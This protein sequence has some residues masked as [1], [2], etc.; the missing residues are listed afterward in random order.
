MFKRK[1]HCRVCGQI[2]CSKCT[3]LSD[4][5]ILRDIF[6]NKRFVKTKMRM[7]QPCNEN[8]LDS[9]SSDD[10]LNGGTPIYENNDTESSDKNQQCT[11]YHTSSTPRFEGA[12]AVGSNIKGITSSMPESSQDIRSV[13]CHNANRSS[14]IYH[15][16]QLHEQEDRGNTYESFDKTIDYYKTQKH[17]LDSERNEKVISKTHLANPKLCNEEN[18]IREVST[19]TGYGDF[20][21][22]R[23]RARSQHTHKRKRRNTFSSI[24]GSYNSAPKTINMGQRKK[25]FTARSIRLISTTFVNKTEAPHG[26]V[27]TTNI[28]NLNTASI[29]HAQA[30][31]QQALEKKG[32]AGKLEK[33]VSALMP[34]LLQCI[35]HINLDL[36]VPGGSDFRKIV[37]LKR[38]QGGLPCH[39]TYVD[40]IVFSQSVPLKSMPQI[41]VDPTILL[42]H[43][44]F[45]H[46]RPHVSRIIEVS[47]QEKQR[48]NTLIQRVLQLRPSVVLTTG[49]ASQSVLNKLAKN[50][51]TVLINVK[52]S[53]IERVSRYTGAPITSYESLSHTTQ[54]GYF[55]KFEVKTFRY[56]SDITKYIFLSGIPKGIGCTIVL[57]GADKKSLTSIKYVVKIMVYVMFNLKLE[58][59]LLR[60]EYTKVPEISPLM[61]EIDTIKQKNK[62]A[63][64][65]NLTID[66]PPL[67]EIDN[68]ALNVFNPTF[69]EGKLLSTSPFVN[70]GLPF[71]LQT[72]RKS[73][74]LLVAVGQIKK[75]EIV[76]HKLINKTGLSIENIPGGKDTVNHISELL[77]EYNLKKLY[78]VWSTKAKQWK[79]AFLRNPTMFTPE[80]HLQIVLL[81]SSICTQT[82]VPCHGPELVTFTFYN[83]HADMPLGHFIER[84]CLDANVGCNENCG[85]T[86]KNHTRSY[87]HG[88]GV[89]NITIKNHPCCFSG[90]SDSIFVWSTCKRCSIST[91]ILP[92]S[93]DTWKY[94][95]G[96]YFELSFW[97]S[98]LSF[99]DNICPHNLY[100]DHIRYFGFK[101]MA[102]SIEY[103]EIVPYE[104]VL[105]PKK[106][107]WM[108]EKSVTL[109]ISSYSKIVELIET[110]YN[111][112]S[113]RLQSFQ[114]DVLVSEHIEQCRF[115]VD[116]LLSR[117][118]VEK[119]DVI[120]KLDKVFE[121]TSPTDYLSLNSVLRYTKNYIVSWDIEFAEFE[122]LFFHSEKDITRTTALHLKKLFLHD[123]ADENKHQS[124]EKSQPK[125]LALAN[126]IITKNMSFC[127]SKVNKLP[128][129][130]LDKA[131]IQGHPAG[132][133][134]KKHTDE[135][136]IKISESNSEKEAELNH[137]N[138]G[139]IKK[140]NFTKSNS[141]SHKE[142]D[143]HSLETIVLRKENELS[144]IHDNFDN[145]EVQNANGTKLEIF[146]NFNAYLSKENPSS[147][148][149]VLNNTHS[150]MPIFKNLNNTYLHS[151]DSLQNTHR[152]LKNEPSKTGK[153]FLKRQSGIENNKMDFHLQSD[154]TVHASFSEFFSKLNQTL[155]STNPYD[156]S[157]FSE[158]KDASTYQKTKITNGPHFSVKNKE[159]VPLYFENECATN[160]KESPHIKHRVSAMTSLNITAEVYQNVKNAVEE[161]SNSEY[162]NERLV[163]NNCKDMN[164]SHE[165]PKVSSSLPNLEKYC[166]EQIEK[167][168]EDEKKSMDC[169]GLALNK[170]QNETKSL[171]HIAKNKKMSM[172]ITGLFELPKPDHVIDN[173]LGNADVTAQAGF[174]DIYYM[175]CSLVAQDKFNETDSVGS[176]N[177]FGIERNFSPEISNLQPNEQQGILQSL[178]SFWADRSATGW[179]P[180]DYPLNNSEHLFTDSDVIVREDEPSSLIAF[181]LSC[182]DY[183]KQLL[184]LIGHAKCFM[185]SEIPEDSNEME[186]HMLKNTGT[187]LKYQFQDGSAKLSCKIFYAEQ[188]EAIRRQ[189]ECHDYYV[190]SLSRCVKWDSSGGKSGCDFLKTLDDRFV[191]KE[192]SPSELDAFVKFAPSYFEY[193][194]QAFFHNLPTALTKIFGFYQVQMRNS[195]THKNFKM[196]VIVMEN[197]FYNNESSTKFDLKG[198]MRNRHVKHTDTGNT[199]LLDENMVEFILESPLF[200]RDHSKTS[201][202]LSLFN[203]TLFLA[204]MNV[205]DYSLVVTIDDERQELIVGII[206]F[207]RTFTWDKK[208]ESWV[209]ERGLVGGGVKEPT[210][211]SPK[212]YKFRFREAMER[213]F[214]M[215]PDCWYPQHKDNKQSDK[216][217][218][219]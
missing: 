126:E 64:N 154:P 167:C 113:S 120:C 102:V 149:L 43:D 199:V 176:S 32:V 28:V 161:P 84:L 66:T 177:A 164:I 69:V 81:Y 135:F 77:S 179:S 54:L 207:I 49:G 46:P 30:F 104:V 128:N 88:N 75:S 134:E 97:S 159:E 213:Y 156:I 51:I 20:G 22:V 197:L 208:L 92:M 138:N 37:K 3:R 23:N 5:E 186:S 185:E 108:P 60:E 144:I 175:N 187:H 65:Y 71:L 57:R 141:E 160:Q 151:C 205:M 171:R 12:A 190:Q 210:I 33:W 142:P 117:M 95:L 82:A 136:G 83:D 72:V 67:G 36:K 21:Q 114:T 130:T 189:C 63:A 219:P 212:Q 203:D 62:S 35:S 202:R 168:I 68:S 70:Y 152:R 146:D 145:K 41:I 27:L 133:L 8:C 17:I 127:T 19:M 6:N 125:T 107:E 78:S 119:Q 198:S 181:C 90:M 180:L 39:S 178:A 153:S 1:H 14:T 204:K 99:R 217:Q 218:K 201:L 116:E 53:V 56:T 163:E 59:S 55:S 193:M 34:L 15:D 150:G 89:L 25:S 173:K 214:M 170:N 111:S 183:K 182:P 157:N 44:L 73:E 158:P 87:A 58:D 76:V 79:N 123:E 200:V 50:Q 52:H 215:V 86:L 16:Y 195:T 140:A 192:L 184:T 137:T 106:I 147:P 105:P 13:V 2:F 165:F 132:L 109:K 100:R 216:F 110:F 124:I 91:P 80:F 98:S 29:A 174:P 4:G 7:C 48:E 96:K 118:K 45:E 172:N 169:G 42:A 10:E 11:I 26:L 112:V 24:E 162:E 31:L 47:F 196:D 9:G 38:I 206:D 194:A 148:S 143:I 209:K 115:K 131:D 155:D 61:N 188:F 166:E 139:K 40:G 129:I 101:N 74:D 18:T 121:E 211:V 103:K 85:Q 122:K 93:D 94:S 191:V